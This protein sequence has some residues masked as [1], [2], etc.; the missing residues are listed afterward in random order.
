[1][2]AIGIMQDAAQAFAD[3]PPCLDS[4]PNE[5][6]A[7]LLAMALPEDDARREQLLNVKDHPVLSWA[8]RLV[9][10]HGRRRRDEEGET[11]S[12]VAFHG[13]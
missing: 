12:K 5:S 1:M 2:N 11:I 4:M 6:Q 13:T 3:K 7:V 10:V 9:L 8:W